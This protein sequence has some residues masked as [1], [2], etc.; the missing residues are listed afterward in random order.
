MLRSTGGVE[1]P[2][3]A[4]SDG[5]RSAVGLL[6]DILRLLFMTTGSLTTERRNGHLCVAA[7]GVVLIDEADAHLHPEWQRQIGFWL[8]DRLPGIQFIVTTHSPFICQAADE[9]GVFH[10]PQTESGRQPFQLSPEQYRRVVSSTADPIY[11]SEAF[12][13]RETRS[14]RA[15]EREQRHGE[16]ESRRRAGLLTADEAA[17]LSDL[18]AWLSD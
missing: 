5:Y 13:M 3:R 2:L 10:L 12:D 16:L 14:P 9:D 15:V 7:E 1:L 6:L 4:L 8:T 18:A 11:W 17:E